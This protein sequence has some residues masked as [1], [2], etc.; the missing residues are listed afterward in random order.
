MVLWAPTWNSKV[1]LKIILRWWHLRFNRYRK[2][3]S[4]SFPYL[5]KSRNLG[6]LK[7]SIN[8]FFRVAS[9]PRRQIKSKP[10]INRLSGGVSQPC[11]S[12]HYHKLWKS[13]ICF[14]KNP[15]DFPKETYLFLPQS[16]LPTPFPLLSYVYNSKFK[17]SFELL[18]TKISSVCAL[19]M[20]I[21]SICYP[22]NL[23]FVSLNFQSSQSQT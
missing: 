10:T 13:P 23:S 4:W 9:T 20:C 19:R 18:I 1:V 3:S 8:S 14:P 17:H 2:K 15:F 11:R 12:R 6:E 16:I 22:S 21:H 5:T 7:T